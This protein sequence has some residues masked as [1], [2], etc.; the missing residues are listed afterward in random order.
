MNRCHQP[1]PLVGP[2]PPP[3]A[4]RFHLERDDFAIPPPL[5]NDKPGVVGRVPSRGAAPL[6]PRGALPLPPNA[7]S[8]DAAYK[9]PA[10]PVPN[11]PPALRG[12]GWKS[13]GE[14]TRPTT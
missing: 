2:V 8:G 4:F 12:G 1:S 9:R 3:G 7:A 10:G 5:S 11:E 13:P 6:P 14:G